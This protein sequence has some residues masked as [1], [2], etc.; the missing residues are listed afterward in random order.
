M[1][2]LLVLSCVLL[3]A[4]GGDRRRGRSGGDDAGPGDVDAGGRDASSDVDSGGLD[5]GPLGD[6]GAPRDAGPDA[7]R[8]D[9][10]RT[11]AGTDA[12]PRDAGSDAGSGVTIGDV[13]RGFVSEGT[14]VVLRNVVVTAVRADG[15]WVQDP[16]GGTT[17]SGV[18][19]YTAGAPSAVRGDRVD[20]QGTVLEYY[21]DTE[22]DWATV[23]VTGTGPAIAPV[24][25]T[26]AQAT[27]EP[28][29][30]V[31]V[32]LTDV[33]TCNAS[34]DCSIDS[35]SCY[36]TNL[37]EVGGAA[38]IV[39]HDRCYEGSDWAA[40]VCDSPITGVMTWRFDRRRI[41]PRTSADFGP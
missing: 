17:Y 4:C 7:G 36:D 14:L 34:Y 26:V 8:A 5:A 3:V 9:A 32:R 27:T 31:L 25:L 2:W 30:G 21:G 10:G 6:S 22:I 11:D 12:G 41:M 28:Y 33:S 19:V 40:R 15:V 18:N 1:R 23:T 24:A 35:T 20:V 29:E 39:V 38:G 16:A 37:W 13:Q